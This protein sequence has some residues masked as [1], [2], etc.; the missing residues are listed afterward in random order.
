[1]A[2]GEGEGAEDIA[3]PAPSFRLSASAPCPLGSGSTGAA[4]LYGARSPDAGL[5]QIQGADQSLKGVAGVGF[6]FFGR[7]T[8]LFQIGAPGLQLAHPGQEVLL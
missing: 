3:V 5:G 2:R 4:V 1:M 8:L 6:D 7:V